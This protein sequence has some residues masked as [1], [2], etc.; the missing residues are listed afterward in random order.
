[1]RVLVAMDPTTVGATELVAQKQKVETDWANVEKAMKDVSNADK[2]AVEAGW[3]TLKAAL[4]SFDASKGLPD[5]LAAI[6]TA[7]QP[8]QA[9]YKQMGNGLGCTFVTP[10]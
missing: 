6:K 1:M 5:Q 2:A 4:D 9:A 8:L 10:Y 3:T 7:A